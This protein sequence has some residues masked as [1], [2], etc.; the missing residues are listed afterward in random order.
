M[1]V[2]GFRRSRFAP[3]LTLLLVA[4]IARSTVVR[5]NDVT[6]PVAP[7]PRT[8]IIGFVDT[9]LH[10]FA[11]LG[12]GGLEVFGS[13]V[14]PLLD[15]DAPLPAAR[16]RALPDSD[17]IYVSAA[18]AG[19]YRY[20]GGIDALS[21]PLAESCDDGSCWAGC[22]GGTGVP[23]NACVKISIHG[24]GGS[25]DLLNQLI[26]NGSS[27]HGTF[28]YPDMNGWPAFDVLTAQQAYWEWLQRAHQHGMKLMVMLA[29]NNSVLCQLAMHRNS[30][31]CGDDSSVSRQI[32][33][34][35]N[36]E[37]YIDARAGGPGQGFYRIVYSSDE[38][39]AA[40]LDDKLA[41]V[42][43]TEVD[44][45]WGCTPGN[46]GCTDGFI[47]D[48]VQEYYDAGI[49]VVYPIHL[50]DNRFGGTAPYNGLFEVAGYLTHGAWF[51][52]VACDSPIEW[53]S[54]VRQ[55]ISDAQDGVTAALVAIGLLGP[56]AIPAIEGAVHVLTATLSIFTL[57][58]P[59]IGVALGPALD[60][61]LTIGGPFLL[62]AA[63]AFIM[64]MPGAVDPDDKGNCNSR[65]LTAAGHTLV[66]EL[67]DHKMIID[68]DHTDRAT[69]DEILDIAETRNYAGIVVGHTGLISSYKT[70]A[71]IGDSFSADES[72]RNEANKTNSQIQ[73][74][75][76]LGGFV[77]LGLIAGNR[78]QLREFS[79]SPSVDFDCG[80][81]SQAFAQEYLYATK[82]LGLTGVGIGSDIN[83]FAGSVA[84]RFGPKACKG[85]HAI[86]YIP[87]AFGLEGRLDYLTATDYFGAPLGQ[88][89]FGNRTW[90]YNVDGF[91]NVGL[92][93]DFI[94][95]LRAINLSQDDLAP[96]FNGAEAYVRMWEKIDDDEGPT[97][98][99]G[100]VGDDWHDA[101]VTVPC[102]AFDFGWGLAEP[103]DANFSLS[104]NVPDGSET[105][106]AFTGTHGVICDNDG[107]CTAVAA[108][109]G[110]NVDKKDP[111]VVVTT[112]EA[113]TPAYIVN[114]VVFADY[115]C[116]DGGSG[117]GSC[118]GPKA[119]GEVLDTTIGAHTFTVT[120]I[121][122]VGHTVHVPHPYNV[123]Y[124]ICLEYDQAAAHKAG[125]VVPIKFS[126]CDASGANVSAASI[127]VTAT[128][129]TQVSTS[130]PGPLEDAGSANPDNEFRFTG[131]S[132]TFNL[133][134]TGMTTGSY[135]LTFTATGDP[136]P[137]DVLFQV[138]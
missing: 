128:G 28:G 112:P 42:L 17:F 82:T 65:S 44:T 73:R 66:N 55:M 94:A 104:T 91:A 95:D 67:M 46:S 8:P 63:F 123:T 89:S 110:I 96:L 20:I 57:M 119:D 37:D 7:P 87:I 101:D 135:K 6:P 88:Y 64:S 129:V 86:D 71:E 74:I 34:A 70:A 133:K 122:N 107:Q 125:S 99:C 79:G 72:G 45:A 93:P 62:A 136:L 92:Y 69:F 59:L 19:D 85:D 68:V 131:G 10:Q 1:T 52:L 14:D 102:L 115:G 120:G 127:V 9:H 81:S 51:D 77:S 22:P 103:S 106:N 137:H 21:T 126:L 11:N 97:V 80:R 113:G 76:D 108:I 35:K 4:L 38:A 105:D 16:G 50:I 116:T 47:E 49:R 121:D 90:D 23:D 53:R 26:P 30:F 109:S 32:Q 60:L 61:V 39:R 100:T 31:G 83:G 75:T 84:P 130:A 3:S 5:A 118:V 25:T 29:V 43:G 36:L 54:D 56:G 117:V 114:Q 132:Y 138:R 111:T 48:H 12:F 33:G 124:A 98:R 13:P 18:D 27:G 15:P 134:T 24:P 58:M 2:C 41:V 78:K 40:I